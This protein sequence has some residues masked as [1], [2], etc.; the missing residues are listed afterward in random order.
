M[1]TLFVAHSIHPRYPLVVLSN[2]DE[3]HDRPT[4][5]AA[6][7]D[8]CPQV[9]AGRDLRASGTW[10][11]I[12]IGGRWAI[13]TNLRAPEWM[14]RTFPRSRGA[15][16]ADYLC[17]DTTPANFA[18]KATA[19]QAEYG[20]FNLLVGT[21]DALFYASSRR[22]T[23]R[24]LAPGFYGL[25]NAALDEPWPKVARGGQA[26]QQWAE[27]GDGDE[28]ALFALMRDETLASDDLLPDTGVG[29]EAERFLSPLF[30]AG[31]S[32]GTRTTTLLTVQ[33]DGAARFVE[34]SY[35][36]GGTATGTV[37]HNVRLA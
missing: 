8:D 19:D 10:F 23:P 7:W 26:F 1:C 36:P 15:L 20:G 17:G 4:A 34:R 18:A 21:L 6:F 32:Y 3:A 37:T 11:G 22:A 13:V 33:D 35:A 24:A 16:V 25:S 14:H 30:I 2:R 5:P 12:T 31:P 28:E 29:V 9:L 27:T